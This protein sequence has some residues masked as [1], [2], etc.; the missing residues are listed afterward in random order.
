MF[1]KFIVVIFFVVLEQ[2]NYVE[3]SVPDL[4]VWISGSTEK[5]LS[6]I[7]AH[8]KIITHASYGG[9]S[10]TSNGTFAGKNNA[11]ISEALVQSGVERWPLIGGSSTKALRKLFLYPDDFIGSAVAE[12]QKEGFDGYNI[13]FE[14]YDC[15]V[16]TA[17]APCREVSS[18]CK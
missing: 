4:W 1:L 16:T 9:Y 8:S 3:A 15:C 12:I 11:N 14:P 6:Q 10:L 13:D 2:T 17:G 18:T 5:A 7:K